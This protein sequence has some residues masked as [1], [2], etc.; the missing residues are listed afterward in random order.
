MEIAYRITVIDIKLDSGIGHA[1]CI[2]PRLCLT[3][4]RR[5]RLLDEHALS[6]LAE[7][8]CRELERV[9][10]EPEIKSD[11]RLVALFPFEVRVRGNLGLYTVDYFLT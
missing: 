2:S 1:S 4:I 5:H 7:P 9:A 10:E 3:E 6:N 8:V 11:V